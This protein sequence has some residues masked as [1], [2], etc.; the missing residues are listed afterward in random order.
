MR[1]LG[2]RLGE[3]YQYD[4]K[5]LIRDLCLP[6]TYQL[7]ARTR[8]GNADDDR[9]FSHAS[10]RRMRADV[11]F[12]CLATALDYRHRFRRSSAKRALVMFEGGRRDNYN[13]Y[14]FKTFGQARRESVCACED[15]TEANLGQTLH[16]INGRTIDAA[17]Q[18]NP[19][20]IPRLMKEHDTHQA[21]IE[22]LFIRA[23]SRKPL[24]SKTNWLR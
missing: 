17:L 23:L 16:L 18:R 4:Q 24:T 5:R 11:L 19:T 2:R 13:M 9:L 8:P 20:L 1:E 21:V 10:L 6:R 14:F 12:D 22:A 3:Q 7:S 15:Q